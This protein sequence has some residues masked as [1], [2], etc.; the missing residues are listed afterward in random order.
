MD[1]A[2]GLASGV[3]MGYLAVSVTVGSS[4]WVSLQFEPGLLYKGLLILGNSHLG[5]PNLGLTLG[6]DPESVDR[7]LPPIL[8]GIFFCF[9]GG[10]G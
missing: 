6:S 1:I 3:S 8:K 9:G 10:A 2:E 5:K 7:W 4:F